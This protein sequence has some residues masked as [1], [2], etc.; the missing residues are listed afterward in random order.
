[1]FLVGLT[2]GTLPIAHVLG[3]SNSPGDQ[4]GIEEERRLLYVGV[5][6]PREHLALS[7][8]LARNE[9]GR[10]SRRRSRFLTNVIPDDSPASRI[11]K[12]ARSTKQRP[13]CRVCGKPLLDA[14]AHTLG[15]CEGC[16]SN[17]DMELFEALKDWRRET[18]REMK[19]PAY[20][21]FT[22]N[23]LQAIAEQQPQDERALTAISGI[24]AK[25]LEQF[26]ADVL[27][28]V[29]GEWSSATLDPT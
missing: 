22:D 13:R 18:S 21:V 11:A 29:R 27:A 25:K 12:P 16:P 17:L 19:V 6:R 15:R 7:W 14:T 1:M 3:D 2:E 23:T 26:G 5:T 24:G 10:K 9:G 8:A 28:V 20:V 4:D